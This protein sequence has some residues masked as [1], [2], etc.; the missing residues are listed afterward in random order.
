[1][2]H[3]LA[4]LVLLLLLLCAPLPRSL[5]DQ[6]TA[7]LPPG[8]VVLDTQATGIQLDLRYASSRNFIGE[9]IDG[10][11]GDHLILTQEAA[12]A[13]TRVQQELQPFGLGLKVFDGYRPQRAV[14]HF[15]RWAADLAD[16]RMK[17]EYY[18]EVDKKDLFKDGY[19]AARSSHSRGS[20]VDLTIVALRDGATG[21]ELDMG[22]SFDLFGPRSWPDNP[23]VPA[24]SR[25]HRLLLQTLMKKHGFLPY[26]QEWWH[27]TLK[28][29]PFAE[30]YFDFPVQ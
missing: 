29:E 27:F 12:E 8:F 26:A 15:V 25:A 7:A 18:P 30:S 21:E 6:G 28:D 13:L 2:H 17:E 20:T 14:D 5:A 10:Y 1:M 19:I 24:P 9:R 4:A 11:L 3:F 16:T 23:E 22:S